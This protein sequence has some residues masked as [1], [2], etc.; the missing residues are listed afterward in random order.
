M[1]LKV[2]KGLR[3]GNQ[4]PRKRAWTESRDE[5]VNPG[6]PVF[7]GFETCS[8]HSQARISGEKRDL[9]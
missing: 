7:M 2:G 8:A 1:M 5:N 4:R 9:R 6:S 3:S